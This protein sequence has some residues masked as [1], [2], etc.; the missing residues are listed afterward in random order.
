MPQGITALIMLIQAVLTMPVLMNLTIII[1]M[2]IL[3]L[4]ILIITL[5]LWI[6]NINI[7]N[8]LNSSQKGYDTMNILNS[9]ISWTLMIA[10]IMEVP[11]IINCYK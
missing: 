9:L 5:A 8:I 6:Y 11:I 1:L 10:I 3:N 4:V 2:I 7:N